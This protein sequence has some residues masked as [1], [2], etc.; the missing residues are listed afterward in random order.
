MKARSRL[1][2]RLAAALC[3]LCA[4]AS[5]A[6]AFG[7]DAAAEISPQRARSLYLLHCSGCHQPDGSGS[8]A[9]GVPTMR[10]SLGHFQ[11][12]PAGRAFLVQAP[13]ARN[14][15]ISDAELAALTNWQLLQFAPATLPPN[16]KPYTAEEVSRWRA[17]PPLDVAAARAAIVAGFPPAP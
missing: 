16:F 15:H 7:A 8:P 13:G 9:F 2:R 14:A 5:A 17:N 10:G 11:N 12:T 4:V 3:A 1:A 6:A